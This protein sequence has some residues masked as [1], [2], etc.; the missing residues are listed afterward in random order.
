MIPVI[1]LKH[2]KTPKSCQ[3]KESHSRFK[4][5]EDRL[6]YRYVSGEAKVEPAL[7]SVPPLIGVEPLATVPPESEE[8]PREEE[9][10]GTINE[11]NDGEKKDKTNFFNRS[12]PMKVVRVCKLMTPVQRNLIIEAEFAGMMGMKCSKLIPELCL[13]LMEHFDTVG[14]VLDFGDRGRI[15][16]NEE[17]VVR[18]LAVPNGKHHVPYHPDI[19]ATSLVF[20][21]LGINDGKQPTLGSIEKQLG[22][23]YPA[24]YAYLRKFIM[25]LVSFVFA[26]TTGIHVSPKCYPTLINTKAIP[27][28][29]WEKFIIERLIE[30]AKA[31]AKKNWF[32]AC[33]PYLMVLYVDSL[34]T[35]AIDLPN[36]GPPISTW[37]NKMI[38]FV[39]DLD[40]KIDGSFGNLPMKACFQNK[41]FLFSTE[42]HAVDMFIKRH[43]PVNPDGEIKK[44]LSFLYVHLALVTFPF[45]HICFTYS[46]LCVFFQL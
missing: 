11:T 33:M 32:K 4:R 43:S 13:F 19:Q 27:R 10:T 34:E 44:L 9:E 5:M 2:S 22:P 30:I 40:T 8:C 45:T 25:Y 15:P 21:M 39:V 1:P 37:T 41:P 17:S 31:K 24:D 46:Y 29:N 36:D 12:S 3:K 16:V 7:Q 23:S 18:V 42:P 20:E 26:P 38:K 6:Q 35:D 28:M 14:S